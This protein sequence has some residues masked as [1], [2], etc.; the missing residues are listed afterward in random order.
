MEDHQNPKLGLELL[1]ILGIGVIKILE[2]N[3]NTQFKEIFR[4][5]IDKSLIQNVMKKYVKKIVEKKNGNYSFI[6]LKNYIIS[7]YFNENQR[8][9]IL[10]VIYLDEKDNPTSFKDL[11]FFSKKLFDTFG[12]S[13]SNSD[14]VSLCEVNIIIPRAR[15]I[16]AIFILSTSG[17]CYFSR[18]KK[19]RK[20]IIE[21]EVHV[22][23]F[24]SALFSFSK[25]FLNQE[26][27]STLKE[28]IFGNER[29]YTITK[30]NVIFAYLL[31][32]KNSLRKRYMHLIANDFLDEF[33]EYIRNFKGHV[34]LFKK[35]EN[36]IDQYFII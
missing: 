17:L 32:K 33:N 12:S 19:N 18:I 16:E 6:N 22:A 4:K 15:G 35:F 31:K 21:N 3:N 26:S 29:L 7:I 24:I 25:E 27:G 28:I 10:V 11:F 9:N 23:G 8:G 1:R 2:I 14:I 5:G 30:D 34:Y 36:T 13:I 20:K